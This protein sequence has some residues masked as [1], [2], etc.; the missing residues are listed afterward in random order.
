[1]SGTALASGVASAAVLAAGTMLAA[2]AGLVASASLSGAAD[3]AALAAADAASGFTA[4]EPCEV[5]RKLAAANDATLT[6]CLIDGAVITVQV[7]RRLGPLT[8]TGAATAGPP[9]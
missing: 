5:A 6:A 7:V 3:A 2:C 4:G 8:V 1:M 9:G